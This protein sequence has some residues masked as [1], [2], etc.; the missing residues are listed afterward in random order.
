VSGGASL[1]AFIL[2]G[3][4]SAWHDHGKGLQ[5]A[6]LSNLGRYELRRTLGKG[7]MGVVYEGYDPKLGRKVA[8]KTILQGP[9]TDAEVASEYAARFRR[10][11][12]AA[13]RLS[14]PNIVQVYDFGLEGEVA[15]LVMEFVH[16]TEL[17]AFFDQGEHFDVAGAT[18]LMTELLDALDLAHDAGVVHRDIKPANIMVD[19]EGHAKLADFGVARVSD[20][21]DASQAGTMV[22][23]PAYM[24]PEQIQGLK[25]DG[26]T[27]LFSAGV[28]LYQFLTG[29][30]PFH[31]GGVYTLARK[32]LH[33]DPP[34]PST[35]VQSL[36]PEYDQL[37]A[38][39]LAKSPEDR[40]QTAREFSEALNGLLKAGLSGPP[41]Q[42]EARPRKAVAGTGPELELWRSVKDAEDTVQLQQYLDRYPDGAYAGLAK[43]KIDK[44]RRSTAKAGTQQVAAAKREAEEKARRDL[45]DKAR[46]EE[47][48]RARRLAAEK[49]SSE[50]APQAR[51]E[52]EAE[53]MRQKARADAVAQAA[54]R[55]GAVSRSVPS[56]IVR[57]DPR[58]AK[59]PR[60][61]AATFAGPGRRNSML[62]PGAIAIAIFAGSGL[63]YYVMRSSPPEAGR[64]TT[65]KGT[66]E[67]GTSDKAAGAKA[68]AAN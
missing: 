49:A 55:S 22:G 38:R 62:L 57:L 60:P 26:R 56:G 11:A 30:K 20:G 4:Q 15:Y 1:T 36:A 9:E 45:E 14:H 19:A 58:I 23:T 63:A 24:S 37:I 53:R 7:A 68:P 47:E 3:T 39:A 42:Q 5:V 48:L 51:R 54:A 18:R 35:L 33:D 61:S 34:A 32:I 52:A 43:R 13:A 21:Q 29:Q 40:Y 31:G 10:E 41:K 8:V 46:L 67:K 25:V 64:V 17:E 27:D 44:L 12:K 65:E 66:T 6:D 2:S 50:Q 59:P 28:V 16:G